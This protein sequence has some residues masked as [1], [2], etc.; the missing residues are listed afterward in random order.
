MYCVEEKLNH[1]N[2]N[3]VS[4]EEKWVEIFKHLDSESVPFEAFSSIIEYILCFPGTSAPVERLFANVNKIWKQENSRLA[5]T[6]L[7]SIL[8]IKNYM[9]FTCTEFYRFIKSR[10]DI[11][12]Q[13]TNQEKYVFKQPVNEASPGAMSVEFDTETE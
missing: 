9:D 10:H 7:R 4:A 3:K 11:L 1:W 5:I 13:I 8:Y 6:T 12:K 2:T